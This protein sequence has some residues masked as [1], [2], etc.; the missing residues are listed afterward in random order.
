MGDP[1]AVFSYR[2]GLPTSLVLHDELEQRFQRIRL[3][4]VGEGTELLQA[5]GRDPTRR[6]D[7]RRHRDTVSPQL[8]Q[9]VPAAAIRQVDVEEEEVWWPIADGGEGL[10]GGWC[11]PGTKS[12]LRETLRDQLAQ[13]GLFFGDQNSAILISPFRCPNETHGTSQTRTQS[14]LRR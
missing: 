6:H 11:L 5:A 2:K 10:L 1:L 12:V 14:A 9:H 3:G 8:S 13:P 4:K 7:D